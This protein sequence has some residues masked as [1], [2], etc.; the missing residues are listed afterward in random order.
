MTG[1]ACVA[2]VQ[3]W[4]D[5]PTGQGRLGVS[6]GAGDC[7]AADYT[8]YEPFVGVVGQEFAINTYLTAAVGALTPGTADAANTLRLFLTPL[9]DFTLTAASGHDYSRPRAVPG[10]ATVVMLGLGMSFIAVRRRG[11][12][13]RE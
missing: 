5:G 4:V 13:A 7:P 3:G 12:N 10:P 2:V 8:V 9:D 6:D 11:R 1:G